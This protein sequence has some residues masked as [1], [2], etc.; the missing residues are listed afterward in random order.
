MA[1]FVHHG[2]MV[3]SYDKGLIEQAHLKAC[4]M[5]H[6]PISSIH[7][8][9]FRFHAFAIFPDGNK[10]G[11]TPEE[12]YEG[13]MKFV[14]WLESQYTEEEQG[15]PWSALDYIHFKFAD[16]DGNAHVYEHSGWGR[17][18]SI[19]NNDLSYEA[20]E[21]IFRICGQTFHTYEQLI[22]YDFISHY[23]LDENQLVLHFDEA[24]IPIANISIDRKS[25]KHGN[26]DEFFTH[27]EKAI[28]NHKPDILPPDHP[29]WGY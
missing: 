19:S 5:M 2:M 6:A 13:R 4:E 15:R 7:E 29:Y 12:V 10:L 26:F 1:D 22:A 3:L 8:V 20:F 14:E 23:T 28:A 21:N 18:K 24:Q 27:F 11:G 9:S 16:L 25:I 17:G